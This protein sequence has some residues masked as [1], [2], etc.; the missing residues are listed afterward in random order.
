MEVLTA[1]EKRRR[2]MDERIKTLYL[3]ARADGIKP[4]RARYFTAVKTKRPITTVICVLKR[5]GLYELNPKNDEEQ[6]NE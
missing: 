2:Q 6:S 5:L 3:K 4:S 1:S